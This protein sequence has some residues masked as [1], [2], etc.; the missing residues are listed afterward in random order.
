MIDVEYNEYQL[1]NVDG[2]QNGIPLNYCG[3]YSKMEFVNSRFL[4]LDK[5]ILSLDKFVIT[6][7]SYS[8]FDIFDNEGFV[9]VRKDR[10]GLLNSDLELI[11]PCNFDSIKPW[12]NNLLLTRKDIREGSWYNPSKR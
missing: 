2:T 8:S 3:T 7:D 9:M 6:E 4:W 1:Y 12:G 5:H 11:L 10:F